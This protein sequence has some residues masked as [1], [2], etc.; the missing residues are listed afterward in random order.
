MPLAI[1]PPAPGGPEILVPTQLELPPAQPPGTVRVQVKFA[2]VNYIDV[3]HRSGQY[4]MP[5]PLPL[6]LEGSGTI[7]QVAVDLDPT[8]GLA[9]GTRV[10]WTNVP[11]SY[12]TSV[13]VPADR[14]V[15][16]PDGLELD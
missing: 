9:V 13:D 12:A 8:L 3:Y 15:V 14:V 1:R 11:G 10:A 7:T 6:G 4:P 16:V 2:G 5:R